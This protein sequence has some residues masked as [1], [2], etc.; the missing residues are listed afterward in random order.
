MPK[1]NKNYVTF[2]NAL[3]PNSQRTA[4]REITPYSRVDFN[5]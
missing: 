2:R 4:A 5:P 1:A 3:K